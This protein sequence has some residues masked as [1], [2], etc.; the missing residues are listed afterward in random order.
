MFGF[1]FKIIWNE[2]DEIFTISCPSIPEIIVQDVDREKAIDKADL[3]FKSVMKDYL[4][5]ERRP[6]VPLTWREQF[7]LINKDIVT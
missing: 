6:P 4:Q 5:N 2:N 7:N 3:K 1:C